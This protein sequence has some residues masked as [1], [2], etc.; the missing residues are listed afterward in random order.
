MVNKPKRI[1][2][3]AENAVAARLRER[4][5]FPEAEPRALFGI[6]DKGDITG[7][8]GVVFQVKGGKAAEQASPGQIKAWLAD[9]EIQRINDRARHGVL[10]VKR[11]GYGAKRAGMWRAFTVMREMDDMLAQVGDG[12]Y[13]GEELLPE[14]LE[15]EPVELSFDAMITLL[16]AAGHAHNPLNS[17][18]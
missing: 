17:Y 11:A 13:R 16:Q 4:G 5:A 18:N 3:E 15:W 9:T 1:G 6:N 8:R 10:V 7:T 2:R 12:C 14:D